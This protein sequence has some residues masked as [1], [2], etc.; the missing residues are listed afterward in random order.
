MPDGAKN[1][2]VPIRRQCNLE[3]FEENKISKWRVVHCGNDAFAENGVDGFAPTP[4][5]NMDRVCEVGRS[6]R[7]S[8]Y[9]G[10]I[11]GHASA[12]TRNLEIPD[13]QLHI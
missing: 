2:R 1:D 12:R 8:G 3:L 10:A 6:R 4:A 5:A 9:A 11:P 7:R 13:V